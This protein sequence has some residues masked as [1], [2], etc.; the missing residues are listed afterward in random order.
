MGK[1]LKIKA[2]RD[3]YS[4][5]IVIKCFIDSHLTGLFKMNKI[6]QYQSILQTPQSIFIQLV[7]LFS[8]R[9]YG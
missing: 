8:A 9:I 1:T 4:K 3:Q 7:E 2:L 5:N 6:P